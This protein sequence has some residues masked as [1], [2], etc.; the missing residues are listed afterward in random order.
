M[1]PNPLS[2]TEYGDKAGGAACPQDAQAALHLRHQ[3]EP[4]E[5][6]GLT[7]GYPARN[8]AKSGS[9]NTRVKSSS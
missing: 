5:V 4:D 7:I 8:D 3:G 6:M 1:A 9:F 2:F